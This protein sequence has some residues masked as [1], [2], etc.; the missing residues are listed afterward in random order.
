MDDMLC[1]AVKS[2][3]ADAGFMCALARAPHSLPWLP[4]GAG[5]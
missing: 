4:L 1:K 2:D 5:G 3:R